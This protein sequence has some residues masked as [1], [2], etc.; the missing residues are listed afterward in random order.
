MKIEFIIL[1]V[2]QNK[3]N[4]IFSKEIL[5]LSMSFLVLFSIKTIINSFIVSKRNNTNHSIVGKSF[6]AKS[7]QVECM[8]IFYWK[9]TRNDLD[10]KLV[11][12]IAILM[13]LNL[14]LLIILNIV[15]KSI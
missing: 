13:I 4:N 8:L 15:N 12:I 7:F 10:R 6:D 11:N 5:W 9:R 2:Y 14:L 1:G 3:T